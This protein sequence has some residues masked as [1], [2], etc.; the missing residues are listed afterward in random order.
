MKKKT[1]NQN[2]QTNKKPKNK[3][4]K[5][6]NEKSVTSKNNELKHFILKK[7]RNGLYTSHN[8]KCCSFFSDFH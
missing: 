7:L 5:G 1:K 3:N 6:Q 8:L 2:K 4:K